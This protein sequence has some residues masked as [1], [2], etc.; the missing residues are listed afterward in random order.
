MVLHLSAKVSDVSG[1][2]SDYAL[3]CIVFETWAKVFLRFDY[4]MYMRTRIKVCSRKSHHFGLRPKCRDLLRKNNIFYRP[5]Y[6]N[7]SLSFGYLILN[8]LPTYEERVSSFEFRVSQT[9]GWPP[10]RVR[11]PGTSRC[12]SFSFLPLGLPTPCQMHVCHVD[13]EIMKVSHR[14]V[15]THRPFL[16]FCVHIYNN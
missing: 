6:S 14:C 13:Q 4:S 11:K 16:G 12:L 9:R 7:S 10:F 8:I 1:N 2:Q 3:Q 5:R 15:G